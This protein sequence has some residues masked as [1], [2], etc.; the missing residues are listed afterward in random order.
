MVGEESRYWAGGRSGPYLAAFPSFR[1][2]ERQRIAAICC[3]DAALAVEMYCS[4]NNGNSEAGL[5]DER[6]DGAVVWHPI[7]SR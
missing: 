5:N 6:L 4:C 7:S 3:S 1:F 2:A